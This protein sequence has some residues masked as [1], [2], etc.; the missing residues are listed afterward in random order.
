[1]NRNAFGKQHGKML[2]AQIPA[3]HQLGSNSG[4][5]AHWE[6]W[7]LSHLPCRFVVRVHETAVTSSKSGA[8]S[9]AVTPLM[10]VT[11][12]ALYYVP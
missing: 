8:W 11:S 9:T 1:M 2:G 4:S 12:P 3:S 7:G 10:A 6:T 5:A